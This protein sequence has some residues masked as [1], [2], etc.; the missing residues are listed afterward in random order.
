MIAQD[1]LALFNRYCIKNRIITRHYDNALIEARVTSLLERLKLLTLIEKYCGKNGMCN[2]NHSIEFFDINKTYIT[3]LIL[4]KINSLY[5]IDY[6]AINS[7][8]NQYG[9]KRIPMLELIK[10]ERLETLKELLK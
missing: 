3:I 1:I 6:N 4:T 10:L 2:S 9:F 5:N 7:A 8:S